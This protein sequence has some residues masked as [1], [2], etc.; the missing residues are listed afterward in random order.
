MAV[1]RVL[2]LAFT[3]F[4]VRGVGDSVFVLLETYSCGEGA[5]GELQRQKRR[6]R[7]FI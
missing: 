3:Y 2:I 4:Y 5:D 6:R 7:Q 1:D